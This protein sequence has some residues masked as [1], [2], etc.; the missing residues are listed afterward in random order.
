MRH[1][2]PILAPRFK[3]AGVLFWELPVIPRAWVPSLEMFDVVLTCSHYVR[4]TFEA[5]IPDVPTIFAEH[6]LRRYQFDDTVAERCRRLGIPSDKTVFCCTFDPRS[7]F[8]R[9]NPMGAIR[10]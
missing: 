7:G 10:A 4:Q 9:K 8:E 5:S 6:P 2:A 1:I 3:N